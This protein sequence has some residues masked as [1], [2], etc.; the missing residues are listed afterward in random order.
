MTGGGTVSD[1]QASP[2]P[3]RGPLTEFDIVGRT[4]P[5]KVRSVNE[6]HFFIASLHK[7]LRVR[8]TSLE[9]LTA[10]AGLRAS[11]A[12]LF[13]VADGLGG[14]RGGRLASGT[15]VETLAA[16]IG[17]TL[18]CCCD[19]V[20]VDQENSFLIQLESA[21]DR[22][23][24]QVR[25]LRGDEEQGP[26][27]T[28]TLV[29]L[30]WPR[31][32]IVHVGDSRA[33]HL[34]G[35]RLRQI[36]RDQTAYED[37]VDSGALKEDQATGEEQ[38]HRLKHVL[39]SALGFEIKPSIGLIDLQAGDTLLLCTDGLTKHVADAEIAGILDECSS[40]EECCRRLIDLTLERGAKDNVT[41]V[42]GRFAGL[43][44]G[45]AA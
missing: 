28:L 17:Q 3:G 13:L 20:D 4:D 45:R 44:G 1:T 12:H 5:G 18:D 38:D 8:Q 42:V 31:A 22:A 25:R 26:G 11:F 34:R 41:V 15:A 39:T 10:F 2:A 14:H 36:T 16:H 30:M 7:S 6:D 19:I 29:T 35:G 27:T 43:T 21:V 40:A 37:L 33:Y 23:H 24:Q 32:Y 9:D